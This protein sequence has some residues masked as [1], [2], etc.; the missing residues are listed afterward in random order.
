[1]SNELNFTLIAQQLGK[2]QADEL[3][4]LLGSVENKEQITP[5][6]NLFLESQRK[7]SQENTSLKHANSEVNLAL[8]QKTKEAESLQKDLNKSEENLKK[9]NNQMEASEHQFELKLQETLNKISAQINSVTNPKEEECLTQARLTYT[10]SLTCE[11][12]LKEIKQELEFLAKTRS[13]AVA[14]VTA[15]MRRNLNLYSK[16]E[17][18]RK[19]LQVDDLDEKSLSS[20]RDIEDEVIKSIEERLDQGVDVTSDFREKD[21]L[22]NQ[23]NEKFSKCSKVKKFFNYIR[24][25]AKDVF[26][27]KASLGKKSEN[28]NK[29]DKSH[30]IEFMSPDLSMSDQEKVDLVL[31]CL[32]ESNNYVV[33]KE[34]TTSGDELQVPFLEKDELEKAKQIASVENAVALGSYEFERLCPH[35]NKLST[36][37]ITSIK[38]NNEV[39]HARGL[40]DITTNLEAVYKIKCSN[41]KHDEELSITDINLPLILS[42]YNVPQEQINKIN[43]IFTT[44]PDKGL[45]LAA[46][47]TNEHE[48]SPIHDFSK[49]E[50]CR[51]KARS[52]RTVTE[53]NLDNYCNDVKSCAKNKSKLRNQHIKH[54]NHKA[55]EIHEHADWQILP[56]TATYKTHIQTVPHVDNDGKTLE[57]KI[58]VRTIDPSSFTRESFEASRLFRGCCLSVG[59]STLAVA[60]QSLYSPRNAIYRLFEAACNNDEF[61]SRQELNSYFIALGRVLSIVNEQSKKDILKSTTVLC[62]ETPIKLVTGQGTKQKYLWIIKTGNTEKAQECCIQYCGTRSAVSGLNMFDMFSAE[63][64]L[65]KYLLTDGYGAYDTIL[66]DYSYCEERDPIIHCSCWAHYRR[67]IYVFL[68]SSGLIEVYHE[69]LPKGEEL[70]SFPQKLKE[71][72]KEHKMNA[73]NVALLSAFYLI[74]AIFSNDASVTDKYS[75]LSSEAYLNELYEVRQNKTSYLVVMLN[76]I[77]EFLTFCQHLIV[78][79]KNNKT[80]VS[81]KIPQYSSKLTRAVLYWMKDRKQLSEFLHNPHIECSTNSVERALRSTVIAKRASM[82]F[83]SSAGIS[84]FANIM[85]VIQNCRLANISPFEYIPWYIYNLKLRALDIANSE[86]LVDYVDSIN[87]EVSE[88][89]G[90]SFDFRNAIFSMP[91]SREIKELVTNEEN[92]LVEVEKTIDCYDKRNISAAWLSFIP[93]Q[94][95]TVKD[96]AKLKNQGL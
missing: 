72:A 57:L 12:I 76:K 32:E 67:Y 22:V 96:Y 59:L 56:K 50:Q 60:L 11:T 1:M 75:D 13:E 82:T 37:K 4:K 74:N 27:L 10:P 48:E 14:E 62:D 38:R 58:A 63:E 36:F 24:D 70:T 19:K 3:Q 7:L 47:V 16:S 46:K 15:L 49:E 77:M 6:V 61:I 29:S 73:T 33:E 94:G 84:S 23:A 86:E 34:L 90:E 45:S 18:S 39:F 35:C 31:S 5:I 41:C 91:R 81:S 21:P 80:F 54:A 53:L 44:D 40:S 83:N 42:H 64:C 25:R 65:F 88:I 71:Y 51:A 17:V 78:P 68:E 8:E 87:K 66:H 95:L 55:N 30:T 79:S 20:I 92:K 2:T 93:T 85:T 89:S 9:L 43:A 26:E 69:L 52:K 28:K